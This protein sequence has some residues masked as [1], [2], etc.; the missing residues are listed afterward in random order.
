[1]LVTYKSII[2]F[3]IKTVSNQ[4]KSNFQVKAVYM[5]VTNIGTAFKAK[6]KV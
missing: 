2:S 1:M 5:S 4:G 3:F 6:T